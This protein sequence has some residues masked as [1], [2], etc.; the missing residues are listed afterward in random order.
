V[1]LW[2][3]LQRGNFKHSEYVSG[4]EGELEHHHG[5]KLSFNW[6]GMDLKGCV[7]LYMVAVV[8]IAVIAGIHEW[9]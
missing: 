5:V 2:I 8:Y 7:R 1:G 9:S 4:L 3:L 6:P